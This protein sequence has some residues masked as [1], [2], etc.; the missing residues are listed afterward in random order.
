M[1]RINFEEGG[2]YDLSEDLLMLRLNRER[3]LVVRGLPDV[4][5]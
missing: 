4:V 1:E 5:K 2:I 3:V